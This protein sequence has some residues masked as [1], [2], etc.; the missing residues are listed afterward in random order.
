MRRWNE[1]MVTLIPKLKKPERVKDYRPIS[2]CNVSCKIVARA[3]T[4]RLRV[5]MD[6]IIDQS[7]NTFVP[8]RLIIDNI[9]IKK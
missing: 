5:I 8:G 6:K 2:L 3:I 7:Q 4:N 9:K 1:I